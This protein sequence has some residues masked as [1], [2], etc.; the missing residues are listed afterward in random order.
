M[1][2]GRR[3]CPARPPSSSR[4]HC[5]I[6]RPDALVSGPAAAVPGPGRGRRDAHRHRRA[7]RR[8]CGRTP[9]HRGQDVAAGTS[10]SDDRQSPASDQAQGGRG[11]ARRRRWRTSS[12]SRSARAPRW[13]PRAGR[14][15]RRPR[16]CAAGRADLRPHQA[17]DGA[18]LRLGAEARRG[19]GD[20][21][22]GASQ[23]AAGQARPRRGHRRL[24]GRGARR[25]AGASPRP[26]RRSPP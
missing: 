22:R 11:G 16:P 3:Y 12:A 6:R 18:R 17:A 7:R 15:W 25:R 23:P 24:H 13:S 10:P 14:R 1:P 8:P 2:S 21:R 5:R 26:M 19:D 4:F 9:V 20:P